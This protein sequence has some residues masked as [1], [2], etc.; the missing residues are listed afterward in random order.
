MVC[1]N[2]GSTNRRGAKYCTFCYAK[3]EKKPNELF[4]L[5]VE[6]SAEK[7]LP[8]RYAGLLADDEDE[9]NFKIEEKPVE[10]EFILTPED[11]K[12]PDYT[13]TKDEE[14]QIEEPVRETIPNSSADAEPVKEILQE[15]MVTEEAALLPAM[16]SKTEISEE[17]IPELP[18]IESVPEPETAATVDMEPEILPVL[19]ETDIQA[20][21]TIISE[22]QPVP[23]PQPQP[24][25]QPEVIQTLEREEVLIEPVVEPTVEGLE[26]LL[27]PE[28]PVSIEVAETAASIE[29]SVRPETTETMTESQSEKTVQAD[30]ED[31]EVSPKKEKKVK[32]KKIKEKKEKPKKKD[33]IPQKPENHEIKE[34]PV[35]ATS[36]PA[37]KAVTTE[38][39]EE[40]GFDFDTDY[41]GYYD[42]ILPID[43]GTEGE[44]KQLDMEMVKKIAI[45]V[46]V[47]AAVIILSIFLIL[48]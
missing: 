13:L 33:P 4:K 39:S 30:P 43:Y 25:P 31:K 35:P 47:A 22:P 27:E 5:K 37:E 24:Q 44:K 17:I 8:L 12:T 40:K 1:S 23:E 3:L 45:I 9:F 42:D 36:A 48:N 32:E 11:Q 26:T 16:E 18:S 34:N 28:R 20:E 41:D 21:S 14:E 15:P 7:T 10:D 38:S 46:G 2:C 29:A 6:Q 19:K